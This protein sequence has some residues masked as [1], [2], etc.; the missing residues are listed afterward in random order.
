MSMEW[1]SKMDGKEGNWNRESQS[2]FDDGVLYG[3]AC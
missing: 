2:I 1:V 3:P